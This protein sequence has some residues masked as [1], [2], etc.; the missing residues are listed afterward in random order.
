MV[1]RRGFM[2]FCA[3][4]VAGLQAARP[5]LADDTLT[6]FP[7]VKLVDEAAHGIS[8]SALAAGTGY[9]FHYPY[10]T[11]PCFLLRLERPVATDVA[12]ET[13]D[14]RHYRW[15]G[16]VGPEHSVVA[17][18]AICAHRMNYPAK[19]VS[20]INYRSDPVTFV[21]RNSETL[22]RGG[23]IYC[24]SERSVYDAAAGARVLGGPAPQ[25]LAAIRLEHDTDEDVLY[26]NGVYGGALFQRFFQ[27]FAM[28][29][30]L[31]F[32]TTDVQ[33]P[34][35]A[36]TPVRRVDEYSRNRILC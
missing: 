10:I 31:E 19:S 24:C 35:G 14:G 15:Q 12:L 25:P 17:Y 27:A 28:R 23:I 13:E 2:Q 3:G 4:L 22:K 7:R 30:S 21:G 1:T 32:E 11:T 9:L 5:A 6:P 34:V 26:A 18:S 8:P 16:G 20:F 33:R 36:T 29:L